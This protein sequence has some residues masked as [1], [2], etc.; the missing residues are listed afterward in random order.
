[1]VDKSSPALSCHNKT[2]L[3]ETVTMATRLLA[4]SPQIADGRCT[5][6][7]GCRT[8][9]SFRNSMIFSGILSQVCM[10]GCSVFKTHNPEC[11]HKMCAAA[12]KIKSFQKA[13]SEKYALNKSKQLKISDS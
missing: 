1:M 7:S 13:P 10:Y 12:K 3:N 5:C 6:G 11:L 8:V 9:S 2:D 4:I